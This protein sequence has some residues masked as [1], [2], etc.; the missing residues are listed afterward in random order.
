MAA[1]KKQKSQKTRRFH[2]SSKAK[3]IAV[4]VLL[5]A[6]VGSYLAFFAG[7]AQVTLTWAPPTGYQS[8]PVKNVSVSS[9]TQTISGGGGDMWVKLPSSPTGPI[10]LTSCRNVVII[11]GQINIPAGSGP[12][13]PD[14]RGI[15]INGCTGTVHIEGVYINGDIATAEADGIA[16]QSPQAI[17][18]V[19]NVRINKLYGGQDTAAH[20]HSDIIQP[21]GGVKELRVDYLTG[22]SNFQGFQI[23]DDT[24][25]IGKVIIKN[26]NI[27][28]SGVPPPT[29][30]GGYYF[31]LKCG[32]G[33]T[34]SFSNVYMQP[35]SGRTLGNSIYDS[36]SGACG[37]S[38]TSSTASFSNN[39]VSGTIAYGKPA[40]GDFVPAGSV[41]I[42]YTAAG[43]AP[44]PVTPPPATT[45]TPPTPP[46]TPVT[47]PPTTPTT[48]VTP[49]PATTPTPPTPPVIT[50]PGSTPP[51]P[52][53]PTPPVQ[54]T[55]T[56]A[57]PTVINPVK[58]E[59]YVDNK[60]KST[61]EN[62]SSV[63][64]NTGQLSN[65]S[66]TVTVKTTDTAGNTTESTADIEVSNSLLT[67]VLGQATTKP[68]KIAISGFVFAGLG[69][70]SYIY[71]LPR[72]RNRS[73]Y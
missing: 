73:N 52:G 21:W 3:V 67:Q 27:G 14:I 40:A 66:H 29:S 62:S 43:V 39:T 13:S 46:P 48:P 1:K 10:N 54:G 30:N 50:S 71:I 63:S 8:Y 45:P 38:A 24:G 64:L 60:L 58:T 6:C 47:P 16:I 42:G 2:L 37:L 72:F 12:A 68:A 59:V 18:Q 34:Y 25:H 56:I 20:N 17:V 23:N 7:A 11:G 49:P 41:G 35:R 32:T 31:W 9:S 33:T 55:I 28:D 22:T 19:Q 53:E 44:A 15:Y 69:L 51:V 36:N 70:A 61:V 65:G 57:Q 26:T 5:F 4:F